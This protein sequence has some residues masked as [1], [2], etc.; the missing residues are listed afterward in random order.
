MFYE[1]L[2]IYMVNLSLQIISRKV[3]IVTAFHG[4][5]LVSVFFGFDII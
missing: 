2:F 1:Y 4:K 5:L 3:N